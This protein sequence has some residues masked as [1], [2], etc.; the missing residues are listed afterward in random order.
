MKKIISFVTATFLVFNLYAQYSHMPEG[1]WRGALVRTDGIEIPFTFETAEVN[2]EPLV[3]FIN[4]D[5]KLMVDEIR[6]SG[7]SVVVDMPFF[8]AKFVGGINNGNI[9]GNYYKTSGENVTR[10]PFKTYYN[11]ERFTRTTPELRNISGKWEVYIKEDRADI[12][13]FNQDENGRVTGTILTPS[14]DYRF[15]EGIVD[16]DSLMMSVFDGGYNMLLTAKISDNNTL[17]NGVLYS[18]LTSKQSWHG[19][20]ND[21]LEMGDGEDLTKMRPGEERLN[22][23]FP[24]TEGEMVS[25]NDDKY[26]GKVVLV[27]IMGSWCPNCMDETDFLSDYY[28]K[29]KHRGLEVIGL[30]YER[31]TDFEKNKKLLQPY[32]DRFN[33]QYPILIPPVKVSDPEKEQKT[34]PQID[35]IR[36]YPSLIYIGRDGKVRKIHSGFSGPATGSFYEE[37]KKNFYNDL[38]KLLA[39]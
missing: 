28:N 2:G 10:I 19:K 4:A 33:V 5:D 27:Q 20:R 21:A 8:D 34:L 7:D 24:S 12:G 36:A 14:G 29:N 23:S 11:K 1:T 18:G 3:Y 31:T 30:A 37:Y 22:F 35:K 13:I 26:K 39:E 15:M 9:A 38:D 6:F 16:G 17:T 32:I 25:I